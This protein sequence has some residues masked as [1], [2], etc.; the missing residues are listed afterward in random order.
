MD[1]GVYKILHILGL[2]LTFAGLGGRALAAR[3]GLNRTTDPNRGV[4]A[5]LHGVGLFLLLLGGFGMLARLGLAAAMPGWIHA[6]LTLWLV[7]GGVVAIPYRKPGA[8]LP[9]L[10]VAVALAGVAAWIAAAKPF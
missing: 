1:Y 3:G 4:A 5:A 6:K 8:A 7:L 9:V 10:G 2:A